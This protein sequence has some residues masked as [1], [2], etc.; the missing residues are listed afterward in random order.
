M[1]CWSGAVTMGQGT[2]TLTRQDRTHEG[3]SGHVL[4]S[5]DLG[6]QPQTGA[7]QRDC[8]ISTRRYASMFIFTAQLPSLITNHR[9]RRASLTTS[10]FA[11][12]GASRT[13]YTTHLSSNRILRTLST[14]SR[15]ASGLALMRRG[16]KPSGIC[17]SASSQTSSTIRTRLTGFPTA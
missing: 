10:R 7:R 4:A 17:A 1:R 8:E 3:R 13:V 16:P 12:A 9:Y 2:C 11:L 15:C 5:R 6:E 14:V